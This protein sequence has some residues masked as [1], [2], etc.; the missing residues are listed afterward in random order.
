MDTLTL[1]SNQFDTLTKL[2][3]SSFSQK[4]ESPNCN[5]DISD[6][7]YVIIGDK[8]ICTVCMDHLT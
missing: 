5:A 6:E 4:C 3:R 2:T 7:G 1:L 8:K